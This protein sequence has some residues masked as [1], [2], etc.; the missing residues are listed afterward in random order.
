MFFSQLSTYVLV[1]TIFNCVFRRLRILVL[2]Q[3]ADCKFEKNQAL[4]HAIIHFQ[5]PATTACILS[6]KSFVNQFTYWLST[7]MVVNLL[8]WVQCGHVTWGS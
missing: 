6:D 3:K 5:L 2:L 4:C 8:R 7:P 1:L